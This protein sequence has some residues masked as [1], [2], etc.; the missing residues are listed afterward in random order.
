MKAE[1]EVVGFWMKGAYTK[2][3]YKRV[4]AIDKALWDKVDAGEMKLAVAIKAVENVIN[5][6]YPIPK[7]A[8]TATAKKGSKANKKR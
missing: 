8:K 2:E 1:A 5:E 6:A 3:F 7:A 4:G